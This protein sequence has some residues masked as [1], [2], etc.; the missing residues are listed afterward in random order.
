MSL[1]EGSEYSYLQLDCAIDPLADKLQNSAALHASQRC[2]TGKIHD[3]QV[4]V[5]GSLGKSR[6]PC[7]DAIS[8]S[9][10][11]KELRNQ[12]PGRAHAA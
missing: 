10:G 3:D 1:W 11:N 2:E 4:Q 7:H 12:R 6:R 8:D 5:H 9:L